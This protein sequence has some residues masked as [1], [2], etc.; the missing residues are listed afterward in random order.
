[1]K[2]NSKDNP[3]RSPLVRYVLG[4]SISLLTLYL[5]LQNVEFQELSNAIKQAIPRFL[6]FA[7]LSVILNNMSKA[8][9]WRTLLGSAGRQVPYWKLLMALMA[10]Q[11]LNAVYPARVG[12]LSRA[13]VIGPLGPGRVYTLSTVVIEKLLDMVAYAALFLLLILLMPLPDWISNSGYILILMAILGACGTFFIVLFPKQFTILA[14]K[15]I[16]LLP[17]R[18][19]AYV[20]ERMKYGLASLEVLQSR[21]GL[22]WLAFWSSVIWATALLNNQLT[23]MSVH[24][25]LPF[26]ASLLLLVALQAGISIPSVPGSIGVFEYI[27]VL[28]LSVFNIEQ[29]SALSFAILLHMLVFIPIVLLG[30][31]SIWILGMNINAQVQAA[32][33]NSII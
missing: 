14:E 3:L 4:L 26:T 30:S 9:R 12:D 28:A 16:Q 8:F 19:E 10:G 15:L 23:L 31:V 5:A 20:K 6:I 29:T 7:F 25:N 17:K 32:G 1:M 13:L 33:E 27:C 2:L 21:K 18:I 24:I 22:A 11:L